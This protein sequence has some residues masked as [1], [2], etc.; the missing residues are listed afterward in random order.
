MICIDICRFSKSSYPRLCHSPCGIP[1]AWASIYWHFMTRRFI[2]AVLALCAFGPIHAAS[3]TAATC[4]A[5]LRFTPG[6]RTP[7]DTQALAQTMAISFRGT[8]NKAYANYQSRP[9]AW[10]IDSIRADT[11]P[12]Q[13]HSMY[14]IRKDGNLLIVYTSFERHN[15]ANVFYFFYD[16]EKRKSDL[17]A[18]E[19]TAEGV[20]VRAASSDQLTLVQLAEF[21]QTAQ[22]AGWS[23]MAGGDWGDN[24]LA[25]ISKN[26]QLAQ[27]AQPPGQTRLPVAQNRNDDL[28]RG[29]I[30]VKNFGDANLKWNPELGDRTIYSPPFEP[31]NKTYKYS[32]VLERKIG[33][34]YLGRV[35][36]G[37][38]VFLRVDKSSVV[39][40]GYILRANDAVSFVGQFVDLIEY[41]T[42]GGTRRIAP[43]M[44]V[45][46]IGGMDPSAMYR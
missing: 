45:L 29:R 21:D 14:C 42:V 24:F 11:L 15:S 5:P 41:S 19:S 25:K 40:P 18:L 22:R 39:Q 35:Q 36:A 9:P 2:L 31:D 16:Y 6:A 8:A 33:D 7:Q 43:L 4:P 37:T 10:L 34:A 13:T 17:L 46:Y 1:L 12:H 23:H 3:M 27:Q 38:Y 26:P 20:K 28:Q 32:A 44:K 30:P